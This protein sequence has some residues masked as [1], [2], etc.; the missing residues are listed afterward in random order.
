[1]L[2]RFFKSNQ[3]YHFILIP[4]V[5]LVLWFRSYLYPEFF[6]FFEGENQMPLYKP[7]F[8]LLSESAFVN[9]LLSMVFVILFSFLIVRMNAVYSLIQLRTFLPANIFILI[10][11][12]IL[13]L[14]T[15]HPVY[16][17]ALF[18]LF[19]L[20]RIFSSYDN[21]SIHSIAIDS[22]V[23]IGVGSLFYFNL[24]FY[25]PLIW[26]SFLLIHKSPNWRDF[27]LSLIGLLLP[28][29]FT[30][31]YFYFTDTTDE[32]GLIIQQNLFTENYFLRG[33]RNMQV[34]IGFLIFFTLLGSVF[35][36]GTI[37]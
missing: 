27:V 26:I 23:L 20:N 6:P 16:F 11:S 34:Y 22:G 28:W 8:F 9:N 18:L 30:F 12:G 32:L 25:F 35:M 4:L 17:G 2:I 3:A 1:M 24:V 13:M 36:L 19:T 14:H 10:V 7:L 31:T 33:N 5:V 37:R 15:L 21:K 29:F